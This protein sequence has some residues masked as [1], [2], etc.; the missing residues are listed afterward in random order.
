[1]APPINMLRFLNVYRFLFHKESAA[2]QQYQQ[3]VEQFKREI[4]AKNEAN[5]AKDT[6]YKPEDIYEPEMAIEDENDT[7]SMKLEKKT[8]SVI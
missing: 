3:L 7:I 8:D 6:H 2:Y 4:N 1:M 5:E